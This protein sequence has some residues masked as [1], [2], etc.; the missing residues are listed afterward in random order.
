MS[1]PN[2][3][4]L[5]NAA[6]SWPKPNAVY[7]AVDD[8]QRKIGAP[9]GRS[10]YHDAVESSRIVRQL[11]QKLAQ[12]CNA[13]SSTHVIFGFNGTDVL[14]TAIHG[15]IQPGDHVITTD[16]DHNSVL[17]PLATLA[18]QGVIE[19]TC[20]AP[21]ALGAI[22][23]TDV[24]SALRP[25]TK[26]VAMPHAS[27]V[28]GTIQPVAQVA[29][30]VQPTDA[31]L[32]I[33]AAQTMG[34][35]VIDLA[36]CPIDLLA[37]SGHKGLLGP[38]GTGV[39]F[40]SARAAPSVRSTRQGGTGTDSE[41]A[42]Q[43]NDLPTRLEAGSLN[44]PGLAGLLAGV[45]YVLA[46]CVEIQS[47]ERQ[48]TAALLDELQAIDKVSVVGPR[49]PEQQVGVV[50]FLVQDIDPQV[51][52][53]LLDSVHGIQVRAGLQCAPRMHQRLGTFTGGGTVRISFGPFN[54]PADVNALMQAI[55]EYIR[56]SS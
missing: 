50:S 38:L 11:R 42:L 5:D 52:A 9:A 12:L 13:P 56:G 55:R 43:P 39:L 8:Y 33:D 1:A 24:A 14:N 17:R 7:A 49:D 21:D 44:V 3:I 16:V 51:F 15:V 18:E 2:R 19:I 53:A 34:H 48:L 27:N 31:L 26:L 45:E 28:T 47:A 4:Y 10:A 46:N 30:M 36:D 32:L 20:I 23:A 29:D 41:S 40:V 37:S 6:T 35:L 22:R 25:D 54:Q